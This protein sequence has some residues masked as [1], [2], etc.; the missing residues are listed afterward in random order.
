MVIRLPSVYLGT[1]TFGTEWNFGVDK[2]EAKKV[3]DT[4]V[5]AGGNFIDTANLYTEGTSEKFVGEFIHSNRESIVLATKYSLRMKMGDP[6][7]SGAG[8]ADGNFF[9]SEDF[10]AACL[11]GAD[12]VARHSNRFLVLFGSAHSKAACVSCAN[13]SCFVIAPAPALNPPRPF[14]ATTR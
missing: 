4:F 7:F 2:P 12:G 14:A 3:Y 8:I 13:K 11:V 5:E 1:M 10:G 6:N 9:P